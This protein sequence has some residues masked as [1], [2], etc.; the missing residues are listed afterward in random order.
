MN[1]AHAMSRQWLAYVDHTGMSPFWGWGS[2]GIV[3]SETYTMSWELPL[4]TVVI[5]LLE[6]D[7]YGYVR[8]VC[9][10][11]RSGFMDPNELTGVVDD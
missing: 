9:P 4:G 2:Y 3:W 5:V 11:G 10:D 1:P 7:K 8:V 6:T